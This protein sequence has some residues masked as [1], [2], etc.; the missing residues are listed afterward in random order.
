MLDYMKQRDAA[1]SFWDSGDSAA[2]WLEITQEDMIPFFSSNR[3]P[4]PEGIQKKPRLVKT[5][6]V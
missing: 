5:G 6:T 2:P 1:L 3:E 4:L